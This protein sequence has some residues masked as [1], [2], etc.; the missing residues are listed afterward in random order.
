MPASYDRKED[1][2]RFDESAN[3]ECRPRPVGLLKISLDQ[4]ANTLAV[5][6]GPLHYTKACGE[7]RGSK[8]A[9]QEL[10]EILNA[11]ERRHRHACARLLVTAQCLR[12]P[13][14]TPSMVL[15]RV[16]PPAAAVDPAPAPSDT[17]EHLKMCLTVEKEGRRG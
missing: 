9:L 2:G 13:S 8:E 11:E 10:F 16:I 15:L 6:T 17:L 7:Q 1:S 5:C 4:C 3:S 14:V 12:P